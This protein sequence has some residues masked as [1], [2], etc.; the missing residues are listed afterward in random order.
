[1]ETNSKRQHNF[2]V[3][4]GRDGYEALARAA[5][6]LA[7]RRSDII[8]EAVRAIDEAAARQAERPANSRNRSQE[9]AGH[10]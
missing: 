7:M 1:M 5:E 2:T 4:L 9:P 6:R 3:D 10:E 8:R